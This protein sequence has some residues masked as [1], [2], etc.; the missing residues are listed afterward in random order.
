MDNIFANRFSELRKEKNITQTE[1]AEKL[2]TTQT[3]LS[4]YENGSR[5]PSVEFLILVSKKFNVSTDWLLGLSN[6]K[7][8]TNS[9]KTY[10]DALKTLLELSDLDYYIH[11]D[12][13][14]KIEPTPVKLLNIGV[15]DCIVNEK[16]ESSQNVFFASNPSDP[17]IVKFFVDVCTMRNLYDNGTISEPIYKQWLNEKYKEFDFPLNP[18]KAA[19]ENNEKVMKSIK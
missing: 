15:N 16:G 2:G 19:A 9:F 13:C 17:Y 8:I 10:A 6:E 5:M 4:G 12:D 3:T 14:L 11:E 18:F 1:L 7:K